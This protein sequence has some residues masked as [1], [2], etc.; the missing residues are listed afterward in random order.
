MEHFL[1]RF[2]LRFLTRNT[3]IGKLNLPHRTGFKTFLTNFTKFGQKVSL[4]TGT[5]MVRS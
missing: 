1:V 4:K 2:G 3:K 5:V